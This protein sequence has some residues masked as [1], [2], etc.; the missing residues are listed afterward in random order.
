LRAPSGISSGDAPAPNGSQGEAHRGRQPGGC[1]ARAVDRVPGAVI[2]LLG[3][4]AGLE[5]TTFD[6]RFLTDPVGPKALPM[7]VAVI[8]VFAGA[9]AALLPDHVAEWPDRAVLVKLVG[10]AAAFLLYPL[11][12][13]VLGF[14]TSTTLVVASLSWLYGAPLSYGAAA[15]AALSGALWLLFVRVLALPLPI[16]SLWML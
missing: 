7:L 5:A 3:L 6:V 15:A 2:A 14:F 16:G 10:A 4:A 12:L 8:F 11:A 9:R 1:R 13:P